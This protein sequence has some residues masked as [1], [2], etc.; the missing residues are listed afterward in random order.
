MKKEIYHYIIAGLVIALIVLLITELP[1]DE[2]CLCGENI[3]E[4]EV[5]ET[6][7][8]RAYTNFIPFEGDWDRAP[9]LVSKE[10]DSFIDLNGSDLGDVYAYIEKDILYIRM[11]AY[12]DLNPELGY[13]IYL[14]GLGQYQLRVFHKTQFHFIEQEP[15]TP[16]IFV[17]EKAEEIKVY[18]EMNKL[19][20]RIPLDILDLGPEFNLKPAVF[21]PE[22]SQFDDGQYK[23]MAFLET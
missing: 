13:E 11:D 12:D 21:D 22:E 1:G 19:F 2:E 17:V 8:L 10:G 6:G 9:I 20:I 16:K 4:N 5:E 15:G 7:D 14:Y 23:T 18:S 3:T